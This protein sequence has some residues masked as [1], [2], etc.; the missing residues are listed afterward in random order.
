MMQNV[1]ENQAYYCV[2]MYYKNQSFRVELQVSGGK[3]G[4]TWKGQNR[5]KTETDGGKGEG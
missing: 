5:D 4:V 3:G 2:W 1:I